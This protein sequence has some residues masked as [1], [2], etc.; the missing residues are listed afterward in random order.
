MYLSEETFR[1]NNIRD[2]TDI[3]F[4]TSNPNLFPNCSKFAEALTPIAEAKG[5]T[6]HFK[7]IVKSVDGP[8]RRVTF[9]LEG[10]DVETDFDLLHLVPP[11]TAPA[12]MRDSPLAHANGFMDVDIGTL[13][14]NKYDN[15]FG[16]GDV[17][18]LP[19]AKTAAAVYSQ[20]PVIAHNL[21]RVLENKSSN[22]KY[23]GYASCPLFV[24][25]KKTYD[26]RI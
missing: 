25:D 9:N 10:E 23:N 14:S 17:C 13:Q 21:L 24:G 12:F 8:N 11:Q 19:T 6:T 3:H 2:Q 22:A 7:H 1:K 18:N 20:A 4:Y 5:V 26:D 16:M 15:V